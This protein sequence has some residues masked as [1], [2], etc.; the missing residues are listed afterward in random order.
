[1]RRAAQRL[2][3]KAEE[4]LVSHR[5][6]HCVEF[7]GGQFV[8]DVDTILSLGYRGIGPGVVDGDVQVVL[9]EGAI[10]VNNLCVAHVGAVFL[11]SEAQNQ[12]VAAEHLYSFF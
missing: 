5:H 4:L 8:R 6:D 10:D 9:R 2:H 7:R 12:D 11:E 1:M 3:I